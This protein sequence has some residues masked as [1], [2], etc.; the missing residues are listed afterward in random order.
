M[1]IKSIKIVVEGGNI[2][3]G[4]P[5]APTLSQL[6][7]NVGEVVKRLNEATSQFKGMSLPVTLEVDVDSKRYEIRVGI[8]T[9]TS[10]LVKYAGAQGPS[11]DPAHNKVGNITMEQLVEVCLMKREGMLSR[12]LKAAALSVLGTAHSVGVTVEGKD[13]KE[14]AKE[15]KQGVHDELFSKYEEKWRG[16]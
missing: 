10:L 16:N 5:L 9:T 1:P 13:A 14:V 11:G 2:K 7:L 6:G 3:P 8:P 12:T 4:P 15:V